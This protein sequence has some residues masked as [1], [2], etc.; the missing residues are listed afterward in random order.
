MENSLQAASA[1]FNFTAT[2]EDAYFYVLRVSPRV[3][4]D[5]ATSLHSA[6]TCFDKFN[7]PFYT[8]LD[9]KQF[10]LSP[11]ALG[12]FWQDKFRR[13]GYAAVSTVPFDYVGRRIFKNDGIYR[14][15]WVAPLYVLI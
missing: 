12:L 3:T 9:S 1:M 2:E 8:G 4:S 6:Y 13:L 10:Y 5:F 11:K 14:N 15:V 7:M